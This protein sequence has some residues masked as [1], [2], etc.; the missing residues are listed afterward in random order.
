MSPG[1]V[2]AGLSD[3]A[4]VIAS[5][6]ERQ[7]AIQRQRDMDARE[8]ARLAMAQTAQERDYEQ[9]QLNAERIRQSMLLAN[10]E[11]ARR[12]G[13][14][15]VD[16]WKATNEGVLPDDLKNDPVAQENVNRYRQNRIAAD[17]AAKD[18]RKYEQTQQGMEMVKGVREGYLPTSTLPVTLAAQGVSA[19]MQGIGDQVRTKRESD[20]KIKAMENRG[21]RP[22]VTPEQAL[23]DKI[24]LDNA[25]TLNDLYL[26]NSDTHRKDVTTA[27]KELRKKEEAFRAKYPTNTKP[28]SHWYNRADSEE[29]DARLLDLTNARRDFAELQ[30]SAPVAPPTARGGLGGMANPA[31]APSKGARSISAAMKASGKSEEATI[32]ELM[33]LGYTPVKP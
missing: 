31:A 24:A 3:L 11:E 12:R 23:A 1:G 33:A 14:Y 17:T 6:P 8:A 18:K 9:Q 26:R 29:Y 25:Q 10:A 2:T 4:Q 21:D 16:Q 32:Q 19:Y 15:N 13:G 5:A 7:A 27:A 20:A 28:E 30:S 22:W